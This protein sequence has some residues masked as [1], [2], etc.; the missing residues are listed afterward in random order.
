MLKS[1]QDANPFAT[2]SSTP[3]KADGNEKGENASAPDEDFSKEYEPVVR[4]AEIETKTGEEEEEILFKI[5]S[6]L[7]RF[8]KELGEWKERGTGD[9]RILKHNETR[10][11]RLLMRREK[12]LKI[13][14]NHYVNPDV[15]LSEN[16]GSDRSWVWHG[17]DYADGEPEQSLLAIRFRDSEN[18]KLFKDAYDEARDHMRM[19]RSGEPN[20]AKDSNAAE[21][22][23]EESKEQKLGEESSGGL[24]VEETKDEGG[25]QEAAA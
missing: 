9:V 11:I 24:K 25:Q 22:K 23:A 4:L 1:D 15:E 16:V 19:L 6:K 2:S 17:V 18:A 20:E 14:L 13:C 10:K 21:E 12:T 3:P 7:F 5:R 8:S